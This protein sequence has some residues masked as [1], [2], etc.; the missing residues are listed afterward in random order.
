MSVFQMFLKGGFFMYPL[1]VCSII[2]VTLILDRMLL[3]RRK[4]ITP[5]GFLADLRAVFA[6]SAALDEH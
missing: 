2:A 4:K 1:L 3:L 5:P 6:D